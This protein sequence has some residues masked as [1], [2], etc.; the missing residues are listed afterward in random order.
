MKE[1]AGRL[2]R[3]LHRRRSA[4]AKGAE[5]LSRLKLLVGLGC[6]RR[7]C[8]RCDLA[9]CSLRRLLK[10]I[11]EVCVATAEPTEGSYQ[12]LLEI[13]EVGTCEEARR[14]LKVLMLSHW[15]PKP[16]LIHEMRICDSHLGERGRLLCC[17]VQASRVS[18]RR[19]F[20]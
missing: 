3:E 12:P 16:C 1:E 8:H 11:G 10:A 9:I 17:H 15:K 20:G 13:A 2:H 7:R 6:E 5:E 4:V 14:K 19:C 18:T